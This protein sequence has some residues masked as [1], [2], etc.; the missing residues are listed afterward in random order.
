[1]ARELINKELIVFDAEAENSQEVITMVADMMNRDDRLTDMD[2][3]IKDVLHREASS[4]TAIGF[5]IATP[6]A[7]SEHVKEPSLAFVH[8]K[9]PIKW[10]GKEKAE[11]IF[12]IGVPAPG[13]G[14]RHLEILAA[15]F[16]KIIHDDFREKLAA[17]MTPEEVI[18]LIG[19]V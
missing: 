8:L 11:M 7:K 6:H 2:G 9:E 12:Q 13:Q 17:A 18:E 16:R 10:D 15:L 19:N 4:S 3:Y 14:N 5:H 1:M